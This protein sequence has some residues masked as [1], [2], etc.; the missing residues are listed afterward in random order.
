MKNISILNGYP[1]FIQRK[2]EQYVVTCLNN[3][4]LFFFRNAIDIKI[5]E[6]NIQNRNFI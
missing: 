1:V 3:R 5:Y 4:N 2:E 6:Y